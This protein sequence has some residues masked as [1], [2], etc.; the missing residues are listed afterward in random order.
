MA[1]G[2]TPLVILVGSGLHKHVLQCP[3]CPLSD[4]RSLLAATAARAEIPV[5]GTFHRP[6]PTVWEHMVL[7]ASARGYKADD[8]RRVRKGQAA[9]VV[10]RGL[11]RVAAKIIRECS[12]SH[13]HVYTNHPDLSGLGS[14]VATR[15]TH[16]VD[17]NFDDIL[18]ELLGCGPRRRQIPKV[19]SVPSGSGIRRADYEQ[20]LRHWQLADGNE[21]ALWKPHGF[22]K[23]PSSLRLGVRDYGFQPVAYKLA[24]DQYKGDSK[25]SKSRSPFQST[26]VRKLMEGECRIIG[27]GLSE[28]EWG[29]HW[30]L[31]QR[32]RNRARDKKGRPG[33]IAIVATG[34]HTPPDVELAVS[35]NWSD[36][37]RNAF[38][39]R[40][41]EDQD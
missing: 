24:F 12:D 38:R 31:T 22:V 6:L 16:I 15:E 35:G 9:A 29:L 28:G 8:R 21:S 30:L 37:W 25:S 2:Q 20:M 34:W 39:I 19:P 17:F 5:D 32:A 36:A 13:R 33:A 26:W 4:W 40:S 3:S 18:F 10:E 7:E 14:L 41:Y 23:N 1:R 27:L 11:R